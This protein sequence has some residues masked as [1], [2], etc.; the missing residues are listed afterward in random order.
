MFNHPAKIDNCHTAPTWWKVLAILWMVLL[1]VGTGTLVGRVIGNSDNTSSSLINT[2][3]LAVLPQ[4]Q[5]PTLKETLAVI[6]QQRNRQLLLSVSFVNGSANTQPP[7]EL[8][9]QLSQQLRNSSLFTLPSTQ[10]QLQQ[11]KALF[12]KLW[13]YRQQLLSRE[14]LAILQ[15]KQRRGDTVLTEKA[16]MQLYGFNGLDET[17]LREDP[18]FL[19][20][21]YIQSTL[22]VRANHLTLQGD[23]LSKPYQQRQYYL[24]PLTLKQSAF[25]SDY[26]QAVKQFLAELSTAVTAQQGELSAVGAVVFAEQGF[27]QSKREISTVGLGG[28]LGIVLLLLW[29][30]RSIV[31]LLLLL[32]ALG[33]SLAFALSVALWWFGSLHIFSLLFS[34][35]IIGISIDYGFHFLTDTYLTT[36]TDNH[37]F[38]TIRRIFSGLTLGLLSS[39]LAYALFAWTGFIVLSQVAVLAMIGLPSMYLTVVLLL[40]FAPLPKPLKPIPHILQQLAKGLL[41]NPLLTPVAPYLARPWVALLLLAG[42]SL[43]VWQIPPNDDVRAL[44]NLPPKTLTDEQRLRALFEYPYISDYTVLVG[45]SLDS[46]LAAERQQLTHHPELFGGEQAV[47]NL[48]PDR[49]TQQINHQYY[50]KLYQSSSVKDYAQTLGNLPT[51]NLSAFQPLDV[52]TIAR[53]PTVKQRFSQ[54]LIELSD[55]RWALLMPMQQIGKTKDNVDKNTSDYLGSSKPKRSAILIYHINPTADMSAQFGNYRQQLSRWLA[56]AIGVLLLLGLWRYG[57]LGITVAILPILTAMSALAVVAILGLE[58]SLFSV[59]AV[60]LLLGMGLDYV[61]FLSESR[62]PEKVM[63]SLCLSCATT[64]LSFGLLAISQTAAV[65]TFGMTVAVGMVLILLFSPLVVRVKDETT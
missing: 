9:K 49:Q 25:D 2:D 39:V 59:L 58:M 19:F 60:L 11:N 3:L 1:L 44:Q 50:Q 63:V 64:M 40:P 15:D 48:L 61:V 4:Y 46:L 33:A 26:Q 53:L 45:D 5:D 32:S 20:Q 36:S 28:L 10:V 23:W 16:L 13:D 24:L 52:A 31:P 56:V 7:T 42:V 37:P 17:L 29:T 43:T 41:Q 18:L 14:D 22:P 21:R 6:D 34:A 51:M 55:G 57:R 38:S 65:A 30:F 12:A 35:A 62:H 27:S 54:R 47:S 8:L